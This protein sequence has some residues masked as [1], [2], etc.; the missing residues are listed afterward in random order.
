MPTLLHVLLFNLCIFEELIMSEFQKN[1]AA[2]F[3]ENVIHADWR[4]FGLSI[5]SVF[6]AARILLNYTW[7]V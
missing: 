7:K 3:L 4:I 1:K 6:L 5:F 2:K